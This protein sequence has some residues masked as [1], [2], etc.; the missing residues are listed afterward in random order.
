VK[1]KGLRLDLGDV[2]VEVVRLRGPF[3]LQYVVLTVLTWAWNAIP[4]GSADPGDAPR[5]PYR[6][7]VRD[8]ATGV[9]LYFEAPLYG[10]D[11]FDTAQEFAEQIKRIGIDDFVYKK[12][13]GWRID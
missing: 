4:G 11:A 10:Q 13:H 2:E 6:V 3:E 12:E 9:E 7:F 5:I 1:A 8:K